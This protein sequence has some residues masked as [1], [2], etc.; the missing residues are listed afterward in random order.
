[1]TQK[2]SGAVYRL[3]SLSLDELNRVLQQIADRLDRL[4][5]LRGTANFK[6]KITITGDD[7]EV[8]HQVGG[9]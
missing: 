4:E 7:N 6:E 9:S 1:M 2:A 3:N 5:G 8:V